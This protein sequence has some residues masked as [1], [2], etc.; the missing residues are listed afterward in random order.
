MISSVHP[1]ENPAEEKDES[2]QDRYEREVDEQP[3]DAGSQA[4]DEAELQHIIEA[5]LTDAVNYIDRELGPL[6]ALAVKYYHGEPFGDEDIGRSQVISRDVRDS[7]QAV[8]PSLMRV[9]FSSERIVEYQARRA[10]GVEQA[11]Q[12]TDYVNYV[13]T[14]DNPGFH[15][16]Y[17]AFKDA[18][19]VKTGVIKYWWD[20]SQ[21]VKTEHYT[22]I[23]QEAVVVLMQQ[24]GLELAD[25]R[26]YDDPA[27]QAPPAQLDPFTGQ[28][29]PPPPP[30]QLAECTFKRVTKEGRIRIEAVPPEE[31]LIDRRA[32]ALDSGTD[33]VA[34]RSYK[35]VSELVAMGYSEDEVQSASIDITLDMNVERRARTPNLNLWSVTENPAR[36][37]V[38]YVEA[39]ARIDFDGDGIAELRKICCVGPTFKVL[40][41]E[42]ADEIPFATFCPDPEPHTFFGSSIADVTMDVQ[43]IKSVVMRKML[44]SLAQ[45]IQPRVG[46]VEGQVNLADVL[47]N[48]NGAVIRMKAPGMVQPFAMPFIGQAAFPVLDYLDVVKENRTGISRASQGLEADA[49]QSTT[50]AAVAA[51]V[52]A[53]Q[54]HQQLIARIFAETG[55]KRMMRGL[56][57]LIIRHQ[58][59]PRTIRL[60]GKFVE[61]DPKAWDATMDVKINVALGSGTPEDKLATLQAIALKQEAVL[62]NFGPNPLVGLSQYS[63][64]LRKLVEHAGWPDAGSFF[65]SITPGMEY[66]L[67]QKQARAPQRPDPQTQAAT[68]LAQVQVKQIESD[69]AK[70]DKELDLQRY[71]LQLED[72][73]ARLQM[74]QTYSLATAEMALKYGT[75]QETLDAKLDHDTAKH[76]AQMRFESMKAAGVP[77]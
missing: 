63:T 57:R 9:F 56:L 52:T 69:I 51:T 1:V 8:L 73:R 64:T 27:Y 41:N 48:E 7:I 15:I 4:M 33:L 12:A 38:M 28:P 53:A 23:T 49:M 46:V 25:I 60:R 16:L 11:E 14:E 17:Q 55:M 6:R 74:A 40:H 20:E 43:R 68:M 35:T 31:F 67:A 22:D 13:L 5:E 66:N 45:S 50:K 44:D 58:D 32:R 37:R 18:L 39:Y 3:V 70:K 59:K 47:N 34:H 29:I 36:R 75:N 54:Q 2:V 26:L 42:P 30:P 77:Q 72:E 62:Q 61:I 76:I 10:D 24:D 71:K 21:D 19:L 65:S